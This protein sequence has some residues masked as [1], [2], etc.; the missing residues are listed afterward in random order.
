MTL[1]GGQGRSARLKERVVPPRSIVDSWLG[2]RDN[3]EV[4]CVV[5][6]APQPLLMVTEKN[7]MYA[8]GDML[9]IN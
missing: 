3:V 6:I 8:L 7:K 5:K 9:G 4:G 2:S 1:A